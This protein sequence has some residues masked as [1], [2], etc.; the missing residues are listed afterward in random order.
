MAEVRLKRALR[1]VMSE[2][3]ACEEMVAHRLEHGHLGKSDLEELLEL[4]EWLE[5]T[6]GFVRSHTA[7]PPSPRRRMALSLAA[8]NR[9]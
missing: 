5:E 6:R 1:G 9:R 3:R 7:T 4:I 2:L 8:F